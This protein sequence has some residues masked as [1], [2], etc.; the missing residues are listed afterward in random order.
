MRALDDKLKLITGSMNS[1]RLNITHTTSYKYD[2]P[3]D[4]GLQQLRLTPKSH[5]GQNVVS[6]ATRVVGGTSQLK[7]E[8]SHMNTVELISFDEAVT[9]VEVHC[10]G[11]VEVNDNGGVLGRH[12]GFM[13]LW[14]FQRTTEL[15]KP[16]P[17]SRKLA[18]SIDQSLP[19]LDQLHALSHEILNRVT[20]GVGQTDSS[21]N[22]ET[23]LELGHGVCQ[24]HTHI[25]LA[26]A[27]LLRHPARYVSGYLM[28]NDRVE[29]DATHAWA[30]AYVENLGWVGFDVS[31]G[32]S[33]DSRYVR[34]ATGLDYSE[35]APVSG[36]RFGSAVE[37]LNVA[38]QV[39]QQ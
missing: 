1:M 19:A 6:W 3:V 20:Y 4:Y 11:V 36:T 21:F 17:L 24:D 9:E 5:N 30:E 34:V 27:R 38:V 16:G 39:Q 8:D 10:E 18:K 26:C 25:F 33:P 37:Q 7:F 13:P 15:T 35:A 28:M 31:N 23:A 32:I 14:M 2:G 12:S 22:A 29:Q